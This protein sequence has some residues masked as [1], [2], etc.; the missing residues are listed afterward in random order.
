[1]GLLLMGIWT[2]ARAQA[3]APAASQAPAAVVAMAPLTAQ[4]EA[5]VWAVAQKWLDEAIAQTQA[6]ASLPLRLEVTL[7]SLDPRVRLAPCQQIEPFIPTGV[8]LWG[9]SRIGL[10]CADGVGRWTVFVPVTVKAFG[11]AWVLRDPVAAGTV[12]TAE[13][14]T[15]GEA[16]WAA[17]S[18]SVLSDPQRWMGQQ[19][20]RQLAPGQVLRSNLLRA[21]QAFAAG[22]QVR[23]VARGSGFAITTSGQAISAGVVGQPVRVRLEN[24]RI[25][26]G[27]VLDNQT[28]QLTL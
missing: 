28:V 4:S 17:E 26:Q 5:D 14:A 2:G 18:A 8:R 23:V 22:A 13:H 12:L 1:M 9:R 16:D 27:L 10:R 24:G 19:A 11:P 21:P 6:Q 25:S 20:V 7:G 3:P 15:E